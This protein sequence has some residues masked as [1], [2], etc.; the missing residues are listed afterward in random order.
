MEQGDGAGAPDLLD[1]LEPRCERRGLEFLRDF[2]ARE[3]ARRPGNVEAL[4]ELA[5][6]LTRLGRHEE[7]LAADR[8][9]ARRS[10]DDPGVLYNLACSLAQTGQADEAF[11][12]LERAIVHGY[13]DAAHLETDPDLQALHADPRFAEIVRTLRAAGSSPE[14]P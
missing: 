3:L 8:E 11:R 4:G 1:G 14:R 6:V 7:A 10:P 2:Y 5:Y 9:L 12:T 13:D